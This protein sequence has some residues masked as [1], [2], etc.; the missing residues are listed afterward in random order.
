MMFCFFAVAIFGIWECYSSM[1]GLLQIG[2]DACLF[3]VIA[4]PA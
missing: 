3:G 1:L 2:I 4:D